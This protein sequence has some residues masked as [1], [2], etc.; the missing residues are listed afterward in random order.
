MINNI[1]ISQ[2]R[3]FIFPIISLVIGISSIIFSNINKQLWIKIVGWVLIVYSIISILLMIRNFFA[4][5]L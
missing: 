3:Y 1:T 4:V 5:G 2:L